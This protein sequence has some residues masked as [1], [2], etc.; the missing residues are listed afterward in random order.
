MNTL[1]IQGSIEGN[2]TQDFIK[3]NCKKF[4]K[5]IN[6][7]FGSGFIEISNIEN[8]VE[9]EIKATVTKLIFVSKNIKEKVVYTNDFNTSF[10][11]DVNQKLMNLGLVK[12]VSDGLFAYSGDF[13]RVIKGIDNYWFNISVKHEAIEE[14]YPPLWPV[15]LYKDI[16]YFKEFPH[17]VILAFG[18]NK[19][20][21]SLNSFSEAYK[22]EN[23][24]TTI[25]P[26]DLFDNSKFGL[27]S[28]VCDT[29][30][31]LKKNH[32]SVDSQFYTTKNKV[33]RNEVSEIDALDRLTAFTVR[34]IMFVGEQSF[35]LSARDKMLEEA[36]SFVDKLQLDCRIAS[37]NDPFFVNDSIVKNVFQNSSD[38]KFE[39]L[40]KVNFLEKEI[41]VGSINLHQDFFGKSF[42][43]NIENGTLMQSGCIGIGFERL[44]FV[45]FSQFGTDV[46]K[47][48]KTSQEAL[49]LC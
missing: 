31:F 18:V 5:D 27:Q 47:W 49:G 2:F 17:E 23:D 24:Y 6:I 12:K 19:E 43:S 21:E 16:N 11:E 29:C 38:L 30:Y 13:L 10:N 35:V 41:A 1:I 14:E 8:Y 44:A 28:A 7:K 46:S 4:F 15:E 40:G 36:I 22:K 34:D 32:R 39:I 48:P 3:K 26:N 45:L 37:A 20:Y 9:Q 25:P 42:N 33:F